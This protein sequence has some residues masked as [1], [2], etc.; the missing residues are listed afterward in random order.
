MRYS[1]LQ[2]TDGSIIQ[3][4]LQQ[5]IILQSISSNI[6]I[7]VIMKRKHVNIIVIV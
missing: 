6:G 4:H 1:M 5:K 7:F 3:N 2:V